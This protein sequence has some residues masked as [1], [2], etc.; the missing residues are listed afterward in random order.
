[1]KTTPRYESRYHLSARAGSRLQS[2][3]PMPN[4]QTR[5]WRHMKTKA[6]F[7]LARGFRERPQEAN[8]TRY[9]TVRKLH[10]A[11]GFR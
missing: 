11:I 7:V 3:K 10:R 5:A 9:S 1:M 6:W 2:M 8:K 4:C